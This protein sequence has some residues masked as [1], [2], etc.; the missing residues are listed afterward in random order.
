MAALYSQAGSGNYIKVREDGI[1][2]TEN[3]TN[4]VISNLKA[5]HTG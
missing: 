3:D 5:P 4:E 1:G 2:V